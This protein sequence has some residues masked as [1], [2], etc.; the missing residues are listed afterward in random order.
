[1]G[2]ALRLLLVA[3]PPQGL[4]RAADRRVRQVCDLVRVLV[5]LAVLR[6]L[7]ERELHDLEEALEVDGRRRGGEQ[8]GVRKG[9][10]HGLDGERLHRRL[11]VRHLARD[12]PP[13]DEVVELQLRRVHPRLARAL[14]RE[15]DV[16]RSDRLVRALRLDAAFRLRRVEVRLLRVELRPAP[17]LDDRLR[18][19]A[20]LVRDVDGVGSHVGDAPLLVEGLGELHRLAGREAE[21]ARRRLLQGRG[22]ERRQGMAHLRL[23]LH[24]RNLQRRVREVE[25]EAVRDLLLADVRLLAVQPRELR[26]ERLRVAGLAGLDA[27]ELVRLRH[28]GVDLALA[29]DEEP[30]RDG[31]HA[32][33]RQRPVV[34]A[35]H[36]LPQQRR[37]LVADE[38]VEDAARLL[39]VDERHVDV[40]RRLHGLA[41]G[42]L[43]DLVVRDAAERLRARAGAE[44]LLQM[45]GDRLSLAVRVAREVDLARVLHRALQL[46]DDLLLPLRD[47][48]R[49]HERPRLGPLL[50]DLD[51]AVLLRQV[52]NVPDRRLDDELVAEIFP[53]CLG[54]RRRLHYQQFLVH[55]GNYT[56]NRTFI[57]CLRPVRRAHGPFCR[58]EPTGGRSPD[59]GP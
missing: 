44:N 2:R 8:V 12:E 57:S 43:R 58:G 48:I 54:L 35:V 32:T 30:Q 53:D 47:D 17:L 39:G 5:V 46:R 14:R 10:F 13:P 55:V 49:R 37:D 6:L 56:T 40:A 9:R 11:R 42:R 1:M 45:P 41:D 20:R 51:R 36:V 24:V 23:G 28:E 3:D 31:L 27:E 21:H 4:Q 15:L 50:D 26:D 34:R 7:L 29:L 19:R 52:A 25:D 33:G 16:G 38:A 59:D 22:R 18:R